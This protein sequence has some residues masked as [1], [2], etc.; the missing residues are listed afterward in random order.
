MRFCLKCDTMKEDSEFPKNSWY[1]ICSEC[2]VKAR[3]SFYSRVKS[4]ETCK[5]TIPAKKVYYGAPEKPQNGFKKRCPHCNTHVWAVQTDK[6][7]TCW[8]CGKEIKIVDVGEGSTYHL[9]GMIL[10]G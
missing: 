9:H 5:H 7:M 3:E 2:T 1:E 10:Q 4:G 8:K 6:V